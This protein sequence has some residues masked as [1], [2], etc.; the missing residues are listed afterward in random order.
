MTT[1]FGGARLWAGALFVAFVAPVLAE[2]PAD[3]KKADDKKAIKKAEP[4]KFL[5]VK[6]DEKKQPVGLETA[7]VRYVPANGEGELV[8]DLIGVVHV[9]DKDYYQKLN[10]QMEQYDVVLY[11]LVGPEGAKPP[12]GGRKNADNPLAMI[13]QMAKIMLELDFQLEQVDY[14]KKNFLHADLSPEQMAEAIKA[15]GDDGTTLFLGVVADMLRQQ[16]VQNMKGKDGPKEADIDLGELLLDADRAAK[17]KRVMAEQFEKLDDPNAGFGKTIST[18]LIEDRNKAA[19][20][21][22]QKEIAK[23]KKKVAIF[24]GAAHMPDFEK[25]LR[26]DFGLKRD[27]DQWL[28][29]WDLRLGQR[30]KNPIEDILKMLID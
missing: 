29:A 10:K 6:R 23:G 8:V 20:K 7:T 12:K 25:R 16:N 27:S 11:E 19:M 2:P 13:Q 3:V 1:S 15:R 21:V 24:Y 14:T 17:L 28:Q 30:K 18:I 26:D 4:S 22:F 5:R 9:G